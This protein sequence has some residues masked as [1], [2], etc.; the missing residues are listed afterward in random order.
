LPPAPTSPQEARRFATA[1]LAEW[2]MDDLAGSVEFIVS[3]LVTNAALHARS[4]IEVLLTPT[5]TGVRVE[6]RDRVSIGVLVPMVV[7]PQPP[8]V[9]DTAEAGSS[10]DLD[11]LEALLTAEATTGRGLRLVAGLATD[12]GVQPLPTGK[13]VWA[14]V[15]HGG[16]PRETSPDVRPAEPAVPTESRIV[17]LIAVPVRLVLE[18]NLQLDALIRELQVMGSG[19]PAG[20]GAQPLIDAV[21]EIL[22]GYALPRRAERYAVRDA[23]AR[24]NRLV[25]VNLFVPDSAVPALRRLL[26]LTEQIAARCWAGE[27][28][29]LAPSAELQAF[30]GWY[31]DEIARQLSGAPP[32]P[33]PFRVAPDSTAGPALGGTEDLSPAARSVLDS[34][35][36]QLAAAD[37]TEAV[38]RTLLTTAIDAFGGAHASVCLLAAD[39]ESVQ[40]AD[41]IGY[42]PDVGSHWARFPLSGDLPASEAIRTGEV[43]VLRTV[44]ERDT[45]YPIFVGT[46][47]LSDPSLV[48][49]PF[50][51]GSPPARGCLVIGFDRSRDFSARDRRLLAELSASAGSAF[52][53]A[54]AA[55]QDAQHERLRSTERALSRELAR[56]RDPDQLAH[57]LAF[58][59]AARV[60][61]WCS[62]HVLTAQ[63]SPRFV[64]AAHTDPQ[65]APLAEQL[66]RRWPVRVG[67]GPIGKVLLTGETAVFQ[68]VPP[69]LV[70]QIVTDVAQAEHLRRM[71]F[72]SVAMAAIRAGATVH[73][74]IAVA[75]LPGRYFTDSELRFL[76][77]VGARAGALL[78]KLSAATESV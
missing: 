1:L 32:Q 69:D 2:D 78:V 51:N 65:M 58:A 59:L 73:G 33:C 54:A 74:V 3:E 68:V 42:P 14:E 28:L 52:A 43:V 62:V 13:A 61:E 8:S 36:G 19:A 4:D 15:D 40:I 48:C 25:D 60:V 24:G 31:V 17:R 77:S 22:Q 56:E 29:A 30:R 21:S 76:E 46:P 12:W 41:S 45:R 63:G 20:N 39:N 50:G 37:G 10:D 18:S 44:A 16:S 7:P 27:L 23:V 57:R 67:A 66:H 9:L 6:V 72:G 35:A 26:D 71:R 55:N 70:A 5:S 49:A 53:R 75:N 47:V 34:V 64:A 11:A 38:A